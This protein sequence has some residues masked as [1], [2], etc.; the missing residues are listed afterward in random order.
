M[1]KQIYTMVALLVLVGSMAVAA[2]GQAGSRTQLIANIPFEFSVGNKTLPAGE[3]TVVQVSPASDNVVV[4]LRSWQ[5]RAGA[6]VQMSATMGKGKGEA[7][8]RLI[9]N[10]Y[11]DKYYFAQAWFGGDQNR[12]QA[13]QTRSERDEVRMLAGIKAQHET[14]A[15][16]RR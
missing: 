8:A 7:S 14:I 5:G 12:L 10:R 16:T 11:G 13:L 3:Y 2:Q 9:F 4:Q 1:K 15:L 6:L